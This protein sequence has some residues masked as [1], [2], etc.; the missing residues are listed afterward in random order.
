MKRDGLRY[1]VN[2]VP[3]WGVCAL[4][5]VIHVLLIF[6]AI[7]FVPNVIGK[8]VTVAPDTLSFVTFGSIL[9][10]ALCTW[11]QGRRP[12]GLGC[13]FILFSGSYSAFMVC[14]LDAVRMGGFATLATMALLTVPLV[15]LYTFFIRFFRHIITPA[16]GGV[17]VLLVGLSLVTIGMDI[18]SGG[19]AT[20]GA[21]EVR[22]RFLVGL[23][24]VVPLT[25]SML[26]GGQRLKMWSPLV[27]LACGYAAASA[28]G[29]LHFEHTSQAAWIGLPPLAWPGLELDIT[30]AHLPLVFAFAMAMLASAVENTGNLMLV[31]QI[32]RRDFTRVSYDRVQGGLYC[33]G[34]GKVAAGLL[35]TA[36][37]STY[38][39]NLPLIEITGVASRR[40]GLLG[41][42]LLLVLA[43]LPK[44]GSF[45]LDMPAPVLG[46]M[47]VVFAALLLHAGVGLVTMNRLN[48]Q[49]GIILGLALAAGLVAQGGTYFP[50]LTPSS[51]SS[52]LGNGVTVGGF[53]AFALS[54]VAWL[55]P[56]RS[57][58][59]AFPARAEAW[60]EM[61]AMLREG[62]D[63]LRV[64]DENLKILTLC[65]E[66]VFAHMTQEEGSN[67]DR[68]L[69]ARLSRTEDGIFVEMI[70]GYKM[71]DINNF[72]T[73]QSLL[74]GRPEELRQLGLLLFSQYAEDVRH[75]EISG[76]SYISFFVR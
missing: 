16:V 62:R 47:V 43:F 17:V 40:I 39:D 54:A 41:A 57:L 34:L 70:C 8:S 74:D 53:T 48:N 59:R 58:S 4:M 60:E 67:G 51:M 61:R 12:F 45:V 38:C 5:A 29:M 15:F 42:A 13:G 52:M 44:A 9:V 35:G 11:I 72:A 25:L 71:D 20:A 27:S 23:A 14:S 63:R 68:R 1:D 7:I 3:T 55:L 30:S 2:D 49:S 75:M 64:G 33:D 32:S 46:G 73:P 69:S 65:C 56:K 36:V 66:E 6:D 24:T 22:L 21:G 10:A 31:Q 76:Y 19:E 26:F 28:A 50:G 18:W 37:P